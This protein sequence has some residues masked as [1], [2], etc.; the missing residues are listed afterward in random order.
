MTVYYDTEPQ[1]PPRDQEEAIY[2]DY[3]RKYVDL[4]Y[5]TQEGIAAE[6]IAR[7]LENNGYID[8]LPKL[9]NPLPHVKEILGG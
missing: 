8:S 4:F 6:A 2:Y 9:V 7:Y 1:H 3:E 5:V